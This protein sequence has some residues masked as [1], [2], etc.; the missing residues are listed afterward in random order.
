MRAAVDAAREG[1]HDILIMARTDARA[2]DGLED[3]IARCA[4]FRAA[5]ADIT[6]LE[7]PHS[8]E[9]MAQ[10]CDTVDGPKMANQLTG[11]LTPVLPPTQLEELGF[12][13]ARVCSQRPTCMCPR[14]RRFAVDL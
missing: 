12:S 5:G 14:P 1:P 8:V 9:E 2:T 7:A 10:F 6:F 13:L 11:G 3:A 4:A